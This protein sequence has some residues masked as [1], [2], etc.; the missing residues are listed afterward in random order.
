V[1]GMNNLRCAGTLVFLLAFLAACDQ[2]EVNTGSFEPQLLEALA[3]VE[4]DRT[5]II[6]PKVPYPVST[7]A[8]LSLVDKSLGDPPS[9]V[10]LSRNLLAINGED[11]RGTYTARLLELLDLDISGT[12]FS[13]PPPRSVAAVQ[14]QLGKNDASIAPTEALPAGWASDD[15]FVS[16]LR[17]LVYEAVM[18]RRAWEDA[19]GNPTGAEVSTVQGLVVDT[20]EYRGKNPNKYRPLDNSYHAIGARQKLDGL[21]RALV[22]LLAV[23]E[24]SL[25]ALRQSSSIAEGEWLTP[26]G[27]V[28][29]AG[30]GDD[31]HS[32]EYLLLVDP[33][34]NDNYENV[35][36]PLGPGSVSIII[37]L[38]GNDSVR[39]DRSAGP[40][41][42]LLG[43][44]IWVDL[45]GDDHYAGGSLG[46]GAGMFGAGLL[47]DVAG[48]DIYDAH[49]LSQGVG[50]YGIGILFD[51]SGNDQYRSVINS[52]GYGGSGG[53]GVLVDRAGNDDY[54][55]GGVIPD[56]VQKRIDRH[57]S[58][59]YLSLCQGYGFGLRPD[60]SGGVGLLLDHEG[61]DNY[62][63]DLFGQGA[64]Y[65]Y[66]LGLLVEGAGDDQYEA[67]EHVQGEG[68]HL[69]AGLLSDW[70]GNDHYS[71]YEHAQGVG[72]DRGAGVLFD[73]AGNDVYQAF[74][75]SQG[76]GLTS[77]GVGILVD[78]HGDD[79]Y[80]AKIDSQGYSGR[81]E[82][83]FPDKEWPT[84][85]LL[86][87]K[88]TDTF[89]QPYTEEVTSV[90][91][92]Q[93]KQGV[94]IDYEK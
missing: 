71:G 86:D 83:G 77:Y 45:A 73:A 66:G 84:G 91:R 12:D 49:A 44:G 30:A 72:K 85:I 27:K 36:A 23:V 31:R 18:A 2:Q 4:Q 76:A 29:V 40:G 64:A 39:W 56:M 92:V 52:Q 78:A 69:S 14:H 8:R 34:G 33:G 21:A 41:S 58:V 22:N 90:G 51:D 10:G 9:M 35:A 26:L 37:D 3:L 53:I 60:I 43:L 54:S 82:Q 93:N 67:F 42:G 62:K 55:C 79:Q 68:L 65:W 32:G 5:A 13:A 88:G 20:L 15:A 25:P 7:P 47:W 89:D 16:A 28:K 94:A 1:G 57:R 61:N 59:H 81:P 70:G 11:F 24:Y 50:Q 17:T 6:L 75:E 19:S 38:A 74:R 48:N 87:L 63:A 80:K 46:L